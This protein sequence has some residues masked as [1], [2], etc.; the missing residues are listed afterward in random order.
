MKAVV[1]YTRDQYIDY[2]HI[3]IREQ[4]EDIL[5]DESLFQLKDFDDD[6]SLLVLINKELDNI[7]N[8]SNDNSNDNNNLQ[9][10]MGVSASNIWE[11]KDTLYVGYYIDYVD[12]EATKKNKTQLNNFGSQLTSEH[13]MSNMIIVKYNL[14][15]QII[16]NN[17]KT[18]TRHETI[19]KY[20]IIDK[21][22]NIF[23]KT[24]VIIYPNNDM[25]TYKYIINPLE[26]L[27]LT[28]P[29]YEK[30]YVYHE[31]EIY[32]HVIKVITDTREINGI[33]NNIGTLLCG[34]PVNGTIFVGLYKKPQ[35][36]EEPPYVD[37]SIQKLNAI[38]KIRQKSTSLTT[39][40]QKSDNEYV[41]F[42]K[43]LEMEYIKHKNIKNKNVSDINGEL[44]NLPIN[45]T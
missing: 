32:T 25:G 16:D 43:I 21:I 34:A 9:T 11:N 19:S 12:I 39:G 37:L 10:K 30:N 14:D 24:G 26:H 6:E 3:N 31:Y 33:Q 38:L 45:K 44:L 13:V 36:D 22:E 23:I 2:N 41:N 20:D 42:E 28:D 7:N 8:N 18:I 17:I 5:D 4:I 27:M 40:M 15:Y 1:L 35:Y 29:N